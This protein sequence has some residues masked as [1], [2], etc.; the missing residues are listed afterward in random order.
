MNCGHRLGK[1][2]FPR[3]DFFILRIRIM[4]QSRNT[5]LFDA[6]DQ[7]SKELHTTGTRAFLAI[8]SPEVVGTIRANFKRIMVCECVF[9][10]YN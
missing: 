3:L 2:D 7:T 8:F 6:T 9:L 1:V 4:N 10:A 5:S